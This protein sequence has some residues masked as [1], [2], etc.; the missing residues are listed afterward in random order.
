MSDYISEAILSA[1]EVIL[2]KYYKV[3]AVDEHE[4]TTLDSSMNKL[5][6]Y[7]IATA[8]HILNVLF[9]HPLLPFPAT[10]R[11]LTRCGNSL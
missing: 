3:P 2:S 10:R 6:Y 11:H 7:Y 1:S 9:K 5:N 8:V 4:N